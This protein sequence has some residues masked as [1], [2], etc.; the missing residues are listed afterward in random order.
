M[1]EIIPA[2]DRW[3]EEFRTIAA[4][5]REAIGDRALRIDH[6]GST[7]VP[8]LDAKDVID[9]QMAVAS[10]EPVQP[11]IDALAPLGYAYH[12]DIS[13]DHLPPGVDTS[14]GEWEKRLFST[15]AGTRRVNLH[16]RVLGRANWRYALLFRDYLRTHPM[17]SG[18]Y[19]EVKRQLA[20]HHSDDWDAYYD[21]KDPVCDIIMA[22]AEDWARMTTWNPG[23]WDA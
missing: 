11:L 2:T 21:V 17:A 15:P 13:G 1:I 22:A 18:G 20:R 10:L 23:P 3:T 12:H 16:V 8:G 14:V 6:I 19:A 7:A 5:M 4:E 9:I